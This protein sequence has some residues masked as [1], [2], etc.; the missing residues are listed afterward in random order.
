MYPRT[1]MM[2]A[3]VMTLLLMP[4]VR[5]TAQGHI[6]LKNV[7]EVEKVT[8]DAEGKKMIQRL[9]AAKVLPGQEVIF[10]TYFENVSR[11]VADNAVIINPIPENMIYRENSAMGAGTIIT[12]SVDGGKTYDVPSKLFVFDAAGRQFPVRAQDYTHI[13]WIFDAPLPPGA[14]GKVSFRAILK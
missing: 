8:V 6:Q 4:A 7:A 12:F 1:L 9:P 3:M 10:T 5:A 2:T 13:R 11:E 14:K